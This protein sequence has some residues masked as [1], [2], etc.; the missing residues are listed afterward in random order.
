MQTQLQIITEPTI[1]TIET[2]FEEIKQSVEVE[3]G[4]YKN[5]EV[6]EDNIPETKKT[7][8]NLNKV[9]TGISNQ[10]KEYIAKYSKPIEILKSQKK[11]LEDII[12]T[13]RSFIADKVA[14]YEKKR[15]EKAKDEITKY[16]IHECL[17]KRLNHEAIQ[18][19]DL[20]KLTAITAAGNLAKA[21]RETIDARVTALESEVLKAKL[22][23]EE[24]AKRDREIA[25]RAR[26]EAEERARQR[27]VQL[28]REAEERLQRERERAEKEKQEAIQRAKLE[29][30]KEKMPENVVAIEKVKPREENEKIVYTVLATFE[31]P[32]PKGV[33]TERVKQ[34]VLKKFRGCEFKTLKSVEVME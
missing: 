19:N 1:T 26:A 11:E 10:Y 7:M 24:K 20:V 25:E 34:A 4:K 14:V 15:L 28:Q 12:T 22:E 27:E 33:S 18:T 29:A 32:A 23:T 31:I 6:T 16:L 8:A 21:I 2:N 30:Q 3:V 9:K 13:G 17:Q 5:M